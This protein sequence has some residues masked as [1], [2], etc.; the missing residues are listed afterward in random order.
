AGHIEQ[1]GSP[2]ELYRA[3][4]NLFVAGFIGSPKM[5][6]ING[7]EA[8]KHNAHTIG[9]RPEHIAVSDNE[10]L[11][12][13]VVGVSEHLGSD[14]FFH[15]HDTGLADMITVRAD[16]EVGFKHG[17]RIHLTPRADVIHRFD[18][19]GLRIA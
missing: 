19:E 7:P 11:W 8:A 3:P 13:G 17:D 6:L 12:S 2:L 15:V 4:R 9:I 16:G 18:D 10:G 1:V 5:N 14:T